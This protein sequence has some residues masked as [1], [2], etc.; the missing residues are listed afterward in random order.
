MPRDEV[1]DPQGNAIESA[2]LSNGF[3]SIRNV[4]QGKIIELEIAENS[5]LKARE[6]IT[7][8]CETLLANTVIENYKI[9]LG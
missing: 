1:L 9:K 4:R 3:D 6:R 8:M 5:E 7:S 2:L